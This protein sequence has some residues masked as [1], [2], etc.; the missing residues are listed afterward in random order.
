MAAIQ[1]LFLLLSGAR[2]NRVYCHKSSRHMVK[3]SGEKSY[4]QVEV[5]MVGVLGGVDSAGDKDMPARLS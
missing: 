3:E 2:P 4:L 5:L 1:C